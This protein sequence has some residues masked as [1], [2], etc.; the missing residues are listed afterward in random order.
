[1]AFTVS[2]FEDLLGL[3]RQYPEWREALRR[4]LLTSE[5]LALPQLVQEL[6]EMHRGLTAEM[7]ELANS[8]RA[9]V[10][11]VRELAESHRALAE[12]HQSLTEEVREL[13]AAQRQTHDVVAQVPHDPA[14]QRR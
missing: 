3:L 11:E 10:Q 4:E 7:H 12:A 1:M 8:H 5:I 9:L 13:V 6:V 2:D 14:V